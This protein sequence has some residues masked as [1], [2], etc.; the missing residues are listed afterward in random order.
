VKRFRVFVRRF[1][2]EKET[3]LCRYLLA[4]KGINVVTWD[5]NMKKPK[6]LLE[7]QYHMLV[8]FIRC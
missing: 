2:D 6:L 1:K 4:N 8:Y 7:K 5:Y 3:N